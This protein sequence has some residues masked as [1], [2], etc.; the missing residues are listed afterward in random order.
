[1][2]KIFIILSIFLFVFVLA[3]CGE[4]VTLSIN[5]ADKSV[6]LEEGQEKKINPVVTGEA[7][8]E[9]ISSDTSIATVNDGLI[10]AIKEGTA[11]IT[12]SIKDEEISETITVTVNKKYELS[13]DIKDITL[14]EGQEKLKDLN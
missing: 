5:E 13:L 2:K 10:K 8:I 12:V 11:I 6:I 14:E 4:K 7:V 3:G 1:M 9:W